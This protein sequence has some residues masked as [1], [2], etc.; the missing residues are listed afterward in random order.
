MRGLDRTC[1]V[2]WDSRKLSSAAKF[3]VCNARPNTA[4]A[5]LVAEND[6]E[7]ETPPGDV[8]MLR[9]AK[10]AESPAAD[11]PPVPIVPCEAS[12]VALVPLAESCPTARCLPRI[13]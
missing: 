5:G 11:C 4:P 13:A 12:V 2:P 7:G 3:A 6:P 1:T 8:A 10:A 9:L